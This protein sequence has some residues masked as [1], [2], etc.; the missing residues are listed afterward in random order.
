MNILLVALLKWI[1]QSIGAEILKEAAKKI[2][3]YLSFKREVKNG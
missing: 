3:S 1:L 2:V